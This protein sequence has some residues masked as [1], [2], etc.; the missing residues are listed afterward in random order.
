MS[1][2][3]IISYHKKFQNNYKFQTVVLHPDIPNLFM[4]NQSEIN[5]SS[6]KFYRIIQGVEA[7]V[8][9]KCSL[10]ESPETSRH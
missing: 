10:V 1:I 3:I 8:S 4:I 5:S 9:I 7:S 2:I 6:Y